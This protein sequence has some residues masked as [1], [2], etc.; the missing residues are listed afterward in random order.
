M[1]RSN[2]STSLL[3]DVCW[4]MD[5]SHK[6]MRYRFSI[7]AW[8][9]WEL[10]MSSRLIYLLSKVLKCGGISCNYSKL[11]IR[12]GT[13]TNEDMLYNCDFEEDLSGLHANKY[14]LRIMIK[15]ATLTLGQYSSVVNFS[16]CPW[17]YLVFSK[18]NKK[19][20]RN[21]VLSWILVVI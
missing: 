21:F 4:E 9:E 8:T 10:N 7:I 3:P 13:L 16:S 2:C 15:C 12:F 19:R 1:Q 17:H 18:M 14:Q 11:N 20:K 6:T 5:L